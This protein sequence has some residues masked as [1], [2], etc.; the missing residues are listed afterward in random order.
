MEII[1]AAGKRLTLAD[2]AA[3][4]A[5]SANP[6]QIIPKVFLTTE[7]N[8]TMATKTTKT[9]DTAEPEIICTRLRLIN[10]RGWDQKD[11]ELG[12]RGTIFLGKKAEGKS[13]FIH[14]IKAVAE[15]EGIG[16][17]VLRFDAPS[18]GVIMDMVKLGQAMQ[19]KRTIKRKGKP[20]LELIGS[21]GVSL[22]RPKEQI[23]AMFSGRRLDPLEIYKVMT[24][25]K[26]LR[27][28]IMEANPVTVTAADL[29]KWCE[30]DQEWNVEGH[31]QEVLTRVRET[32]EERRKKAGQVFDQAKAA[33]T[34]KAGDANRLRVEKPET[35]TPEAART[36]VAAAERELAVLFDRSKQA[37]KR[38]AEAA[39]TRAK[40]AELRAKAEELMAYPEAAI[41]SPANL[42][43]RCSAWIARITCPKLECQIPPSQEGVIDL[44]G[45]ALD[46]LDKQIAGV[47]GELSK[48]A[49]AMGIARK[50]EA[51]ATAAINQ[52]N[53]LEAAIA[54]TL[55]GDGDPIA[56]QALAALDA[57]DEARALVERSEA[58]AK[59][60]AAKQE[61]TT[62]EATLQAADDE[63]ERLN[64]IAVRL[65][66]E[67]PADLSKRSDMIE[68]LEITPD[69]VMLD[70]RSLTVISGGE[71]LEFAVKL[72]K[73]M[74]GKAKILT[75]DG[76][77][78]ISPEEQPAFVRLC[79][80]GGW[81]LFA[82]V[83]CD[84]PLQ[85]VD[86][87]TFA[88]KAA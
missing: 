24:D 27:Q 10:F 53:E 44:A 37:E 63:W 1:N 60:R 76:M 61:L 39:G 56:I 78:A 21:D 65:A 3:M 8:E 75:V 41:P 15:A 54:H 66:K 82:T 68:G 31:G 29:N 59:W 81:I 26:K 35:I 72:A 67:A 57:I 9:A 71:R 52:A 84:G 12:P 88:Q 42:M 30:T 80:E 45:Y 2:V 14:A 77:E 18:G 69:A 55:D 70:G 23:D 58:T 79:L 34:M 47:R 28:I 4:P 5:E 25:A 87:F 43:G 74:G 13:S 40:V 46:D 17:E 51:D 83:V 64:R 36:H 33:V 32:Y 73:R 6:A 7:E 38:E 19:I 49:I 11:I 85:I 22:P 62:A 20:E 16:P 50:M 48:A 86:A